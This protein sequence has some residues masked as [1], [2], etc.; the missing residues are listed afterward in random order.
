MTKKKW[1]S[2][3]LILVAILATV[4]LVNCGGQEATT[5]EEVAEE[6]APEVEEE[7]AEAEA[8]EPEAEAE[9][10][11]EVEEPEGLTPEQ[12]TEEWTGSGHNDAEAEAFVHWDEDDP[13]E[14]PTSCAKCHSA[15]G[16]L[17]FLGE[18]GTEFGVVDNAAEIGTTITC[19][20]CHNDTAEATTSVVFP[21]GVEI[22]DIG[23]SARCMQCHQGRSST[24]TVNEAIVDLPLDSPN[25][26]LGF[27]NIHYFAAGA[28]LY[29]GEVQA[30]YQYEGKVY[31]PRTS[32]PAPYQECTD[33]HNMHSLEVK[34]EECGE[35]HEGVSTVDDLLDTRME[36]SLE[37]YDGD[38][39]AEEGMYYELQG[40]QELLYQ[41]ILA[42]SAEKGAPVVYESHTYPYFFADTNAD[43]EPG[44]DEAIYPNRYATWTPRLLQAAYNYQYAAKDPGAFAHNPKYV[45]AL[46]YDSIESLNEGM[47]APAVDLS[48][49]SR[50]DPGHFDGTAEAF[51]HWDEAD[52]GEEV[53]PP[54][55]C[56]RCHS[57]EGLPLYLE[58]GSAV[59]QPPANAFACA[60]CHTFEDGVQVREAGEVT[61]P[62]G[63]VASFPDNP[64]SNL[65]MVC[66]QGRSSTVSVNDAIAGID[67]DAVG[68]ELGFINIHYFAAGATRFGGDAQGGYEYEGKDY[69][70]FFP[71]VPDFDACSECHNVHALEVK[72]D[73]CL[74][75][76]DG[77]LE[78]YRKASGDFDGDGDEDEGVVGEIETLKED[79]Y[80]AIQAYARA[81][82]DTDAVIYNS[83]AYP[84]FFI[85]TNA[86]GA[87][88]PGEG[89][90]PNKYATWTPTLLQAAY[91]Y[92][93]A[94]KDPGGYAHNAPYVTQL[95]IDSI[96]AVGGDVSG[97]NRP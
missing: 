63:A 29:G 38:G 87:V 11:E 71:H 57:A 78:E 84:Y 30:G 67:A 97:Y 7:E 76:H 34:A 13:A 36:G 19:D 70:G 25:P 82:A 54:E 37:D 58:D 5:E 1:L 65:C 9:E 77:E 68:E 24:V 31:Q 91:N 39:D 35:C 72:A 44:E 94:S 73:E 83:H 60:T 3:L 12:A 69:A 27:I 85:D 80:A 16:H 64:E 6:P 50:N 95:L 61:F 56:S 18:D 23:P 22:A 28:T 49:V 8:E 43:G 89:I 20:V 14:V 33:C 21:S 52:E 48:T 81:N 26:D 53:G 46:L 17:D 2:G 66:H 75:C 93:Y 47:S 40:L 41:A 86:N 55:S 4:V 90:Y 10:M 96:E 59:A 42:Y 51:R 79:L 92:Q 88:D 32:H 45:A 15:G 74:M 62:S